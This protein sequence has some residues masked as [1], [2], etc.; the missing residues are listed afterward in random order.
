[1][2]AFLGMN[3]SPKIQPVGISLAWG[4]QH[5]LEVGA[6]LL[7]FKISSNKMTVLRLPDNMR[8][9]DDLVSCNKAIH[10]KKNTTSIN[11]FSE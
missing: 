8:M 11:Y 1:M 10:V 2:L 4:Q 3:K 9:S 6:W 7:V 5:G